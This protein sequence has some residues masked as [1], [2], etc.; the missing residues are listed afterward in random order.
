M[1]KRNTRV[2][3]RVLEGVAAPNQEGDEIVA[4][5]VGYVL[6]LG[7]QLAVAVDAVPGQVGADVS[8]GSGLRRLHLARLDDLD[9]GAGL[10]VALAK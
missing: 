3:H 7:L 4:P 10:R 2:E 5:I 8:A 9:D 1:A 6:D